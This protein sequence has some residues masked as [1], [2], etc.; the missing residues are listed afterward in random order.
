MATLVTPALRRFLATGFQ[1][2]PER[3][4]PDYGLVCLVSGRQRIYVNP[5]TGDCRVGSNTPGNRG[6]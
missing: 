1:R 6:H 3:D 4:A 2:L 5:E